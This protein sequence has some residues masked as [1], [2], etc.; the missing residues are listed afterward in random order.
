MQEQKTTLVSGIRHCNPQ[1]KPTEQGTDENKKKKHGQAGRLQINQTTTLWLLLRHLLTTPWVV[2]T[3]KPSLLRHELLLLTT[4]E[5]IVAR[6]CCL[7]ASQTLSRRVDKCARRSMLRGNTEVAHVS[8]GI[9]T[10][11]RREQGVQTCVVRV[12]HLWRRALGRLR[13]GNRRRLEVGDWVGS[14]GGELR[15][16]AVFCEGVE[17]RGTRCQWRSGSVGELGASCEGVVGAG[18]HG[19]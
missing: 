19:F 5:W 10:F 15:R 8:K 4:K 17:S 1:P 7:Q 3:N 12:V 9:L 13:S 6:L 2:I 11:S 18:W 14:A 16:G